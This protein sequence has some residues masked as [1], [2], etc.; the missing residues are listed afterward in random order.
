MRDVP[1]FRRV[2][3]HNVY[4]GVDVAWYGSEGQLEYDLVVRPGADTGHIA[5]RFDGARKL[6]VEPNGDLRIE[7]TDGSLTLRVPVVYQESGGARQRIEGHYVLRVDNEVT[8]ALAN[9]DKS[10]PLVIDPTLVYA[11]WFP[12]QDVWVTAMAMD[13]QGNIY[14]GGYASW[15]P[16]VSAY[17]PGADVPLHGPVCDQVRSNWNHNALRHIR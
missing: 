10:R 13:P 6:E 16:V 1:T 9:Y 4:E 12:G 8:F 17:E 2:L 3:Y 5:L 15:L 11:A 7:T 14:L